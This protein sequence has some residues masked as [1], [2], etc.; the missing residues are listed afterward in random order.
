MDNRKRYV[1]KIE[2]YS[3]KSGSDG[4][5]FEVEN[6]KYFCTLESVINGST[7]KNFHN[8]KDFAKTMIEENM[9]NKIPFRVIVEEDW[10]DRIDTR[11]NRRNEH[12]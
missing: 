5:I 10:N 2:E 9:I 3:G 1:M 11:T 8:A 12:S 7:P 4:R 6:K